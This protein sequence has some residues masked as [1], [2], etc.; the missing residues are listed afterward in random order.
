MPGSAIPLVARIVSV[1]DCFN[2]MIGRR[3]YRAA[4]P[5]D[6]ALEQLKAHAGTQFDAEV[7]AAM[8]DVVGRA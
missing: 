8:H 3:P 6:R 2:A 7:V 4:M 5:P 1:A